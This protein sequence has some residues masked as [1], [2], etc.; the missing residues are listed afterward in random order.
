MDH[1]TIFALLQ[2]AFG[3]VMGWISYGLFKDNK[4]YRK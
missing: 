1:T 4:R 2:I 3:F